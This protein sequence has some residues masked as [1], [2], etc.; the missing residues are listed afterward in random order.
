MKV[1]ILAFLGVLAGVA[2]SHGSRPFRLAQNVDNSRIHWYFCT[3]KACGA[4]Y[5]GKAFLTHCAIELEKNGECK[6]KKDKPKYR[7]E[8]KDIKENHEFFAHM[9]IVPADQVY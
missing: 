2:C 5:K 4:D 1:F 6:E 3:E 9:I 7:Y 8:I